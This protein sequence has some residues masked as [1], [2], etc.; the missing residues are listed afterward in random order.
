[1]FKGGRRGT[2]DERKQKLNCE[3]DS[4]WIVIKVQVAIDSG[5]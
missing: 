5:D 3:K 2:R 4:E 1:M